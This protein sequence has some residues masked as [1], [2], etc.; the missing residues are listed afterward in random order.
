MYIKTSNG[1]AEKLRFTYRPGEFT[2]SKLD[3]EMEFE[4]PSY[5]Y[6]AP[7]P[8]QD[9]LLIKMRDFRDKEGNLIVEAFEVEKPIPSQVDGDFAVALDI[10]G[11]LAAGTVGGSFSFNF[12]LNLLMGTS[13]SQLLGSIKP[14]QVIIHLSLMSVEVPGAAQSIF[15]AIAEL[16]VFDPIPVE[17]EINE[18]FELAHEDD[19]ELNTNF[20]QLDYETPYCVANLGSLLFIIMLQ[21]AL[22]PIIVSMALVLKCCPKV[23][24]WSVRK[25]GGIFFNSILTFIDG[26]FLAIALMAAINMKAAADG[27]VPYDASFAISVISLLVCVGELVAITV[28]LKLAHKRGKLADE[29]S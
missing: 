6:G 17:D 7:N 5:V 3:L 13:M 2:D 12:I 18:L 15:G 11:G 26:T 19:N 10:A 24:R 8:D 22:I 9:K 28:F 4:N 1:Y 25:M 29:K 23:Q 27:K 16:V 14:L 20:Q 21:L